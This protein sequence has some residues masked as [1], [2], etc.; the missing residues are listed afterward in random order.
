M[1]LYEQNGDEITIICD[2]C[3]VPYVT[4]KKTEHMTDVW[5]SE[6]TE[7]GW[8]ITMVSPIPYGG[9][10]ICPEC[11]AKLDG[12]LKQPMMDVYNLILTKSGCPNAGSSALRAFFA[13][14]CSRYV[15]Q[16]QKD[17]QTKEC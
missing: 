6:L 16:A 5:I 2:M 3:D 13:Q 8:F 9:I 1:R 14:L 4:H 12:V 7:L 10:D 11:L 17:K 15:A